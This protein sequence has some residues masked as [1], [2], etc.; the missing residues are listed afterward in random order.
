MFKNPFRRHSPPSGTFA[1]PAHFAS[2]TRSLPRGKLFAPVRPFGKQAGLNPTAREFPFPSLSGSQPGFTS[3][4]PSF[5]IPR[6]HAISRKQAP[7]LPSNQFVPLQE[8]H[9]PFACAKK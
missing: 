2:V 3:P 7:F 5:P 4:V 8:S 1:L 6:I 9:L